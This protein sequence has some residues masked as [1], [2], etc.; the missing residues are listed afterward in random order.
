MGPL[1][2]I[3]FFMPFIVVAAI[4]IVKGLMRKERGQLPGMP[5]GLGFMT[6]VLFV[7]YTCLYELLAWVMEMAALPQYEARPQ[8]MY[9]ICVQFVFIAAAFI[10]LFAPLSFKNK[11][12]S[13]ERQCGKKLKSQSLMIGSFII[14]INMSV[15]ILDFL[16]SLLAFLITDSGGFVSR[17]SEI[18]KESFAVQLF[19]DLI[20]LIAGVLAV[21][22]GNKKSLQL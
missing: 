16:I 17:F 21:H 8:E 1:F 9:W 14:V 2:S 13:V 20:F 15:N 18:P 6:T 4:T 3:L 7:L 22:N 12:I 11:F 5:A 10:M 19:P